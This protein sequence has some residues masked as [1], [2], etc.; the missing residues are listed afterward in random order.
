M[1]ADDLT[2]WT[3]AC[4]AD[5]LSE[6]LQAAANIISNWCRDNN[7]IVSPKTDGIIFTRSSQHHDE[8]TVNCDD[9]QIPLKNYFVDQS[10]TQSKTFT[11]LGVVLDPQLTFGRHTESIL[12]RSKKSINQLRAIA[13]SSWGPTSHTLR[14]F[15]KGLVESVLLYGAEIWWPLLSETHKEKLREC[16]RAA[17]RVVTGC[18]KTTVNDLLHLEADVPPLDALAEAR[19]SSYLEKCCRFSANDMRK[20]LREPIPTLSAPVNSQHLQPTE[21]LLTASRH[22]LN[23]SENM[24]ESFEHP[25]SPYDTSKADKV[26]FGL[27]TDLPVPFVTTDRSE[28]AN[29]ARRSSSVATILRLRLGTSLKAPRSILRDPTLPKSRTTPR[30]LQICAKQIDEEP[31]PLKIYELWTDAS[32]DGDGLGSGVGLLFEKDEMTHL[33]AAFA[34]TGTCSYR[35]ESLAVEQTL[36]DLVDRFHHQHPSKKKRHRVLLFTDSYALVSALAK[37]PLLQQGAAEIRIWRLLRKLTAKNVLCHIQFIYSHC[38]IERNEQADAAAKQLNEHQREHPQ[39]GRASWLKDDCRHLRQQINARLAPQSTPLCRSTHSFNPATPRT[40]STR[41]ARL[42]TGESL[43]IG[44]GR[45]RVGLDQSMAC[46]FCHRHLHSQ[47]APSSPERSRRLFRSSD[48]QSC[49]HRVCRDH[50]PFANVRSLRQHW[51]TLHSGEPLPARFQS[52][53]LPDPR[54]PTPASSQRQRRP[55]DGTSFPDGTIICPFCAKRVRPG[56][57]VRCRDRQ[58][59]QSSRFLFPCP[60]CGKRAPAQHIVHCPEKAAPPPREIPTRLQPTVC[61]ETVPHVFLDCRALAPLRRRVLPWSLNVSPDERDKILAQQL[62]QEDPTILSF[63]EE[64]NN[65]TAV[66][67]T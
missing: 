1:Y 61:D 30:P 66:R 32:I 4:P 28:E 67:V 19:V 39:E 17:L 27:A 54:V 13:G 41:F 48:P 15:Y 65:L 21:T 40:V 63:L 12:G 60:T 9:L 46:R 2:V 56:H 24:K 52:N 11:L 37:G 18:M 7:M 43:E 25:I 42:R 62:A 35:G 50:R 10:H 38:G 16:H 23:T 45:R 6:P 14:V 59:G 64:I 34:G 26:T 53:R 8:I 20:S 22:L 5:A 58:P 55:S 31:L 47:E 49:P 29:E 3:A 57:L 33:S 44:I 51:Q 36:S